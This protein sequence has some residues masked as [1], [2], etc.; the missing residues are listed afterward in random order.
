MRPWIICKVY[1]SRLK[2][3]DVAH[4]RTDVDFWVRLHDFNHV[5]K[6]HGAVTL[7]LKLLC[8][9]LSD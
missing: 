2:A 3:K 1:R 6:V 8:V 9:G 5:L 4:E 7:H